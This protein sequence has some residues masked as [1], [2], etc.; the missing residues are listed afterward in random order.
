MPYHFPLTEGVPCP[1]E[2][3]LPRTHKFLTTLLAL[4]IDFDELGWM[5]LG[6]GGAS[7]VSSIGTDLS[8]MSKYSIIF[9]ISIIP[10]ESAYRYFL[11][12]FFIPFLD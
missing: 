3:M 9:I 10:T 11:T 8:A 12:F 1:Y 4:P 2:T 6:G 7:M 5:V